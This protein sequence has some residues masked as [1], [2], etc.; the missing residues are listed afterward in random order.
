MKWY[1]WTVAKLG[2]AA[3]TLRRRWSGFDV[4]EQALICSNILQLEEGQERPSVVTHLENL[5]DSRIAMDTV[6]A[7]LV[8]PPSPVGNMQ[9]THPGQSTSQAQS[10]D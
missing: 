9:L 8:R 6:L 2:K 4:N 10:P 7:K 3:S 1:W 5:Y